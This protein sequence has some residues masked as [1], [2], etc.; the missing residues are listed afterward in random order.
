MRILNG[1]DF[2]AAVTLRLPGP[3]RGLGRRRYRRYVANI[4]PAVQADEDALLTIHLATWTTDVSPDGTPDPAEPFFDAHTSLRDVLVADDDGRAVGYVRLNQPGPLPS[5]AHV[6]EINGLAVDPGRQGAGI[7]RRLIEAALVEARSRGARKVSLRVLAPNAR[8][9]RLYTSC[10]F[11]LE[12]ALRAE[13]LL[14]DRYVDDLFL[15]HHLAPAAL[16]SKR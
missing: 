13:F 8:A 2:G 7:G 1:T 5:H 6:L 4:R 16:P 9:R 11:V 15:A 14:D 12:G 10:G 3:V